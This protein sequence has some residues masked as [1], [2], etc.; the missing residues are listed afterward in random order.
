[1]YDS[2]IRPILLAPSYLK[3]ISGRSMQLVWHRAAEALL[4]AEQVE[5][6]GASLPSADS[7]VRA[8]LN[9]LRFRSDEGRVAL[10]V[11][12]PSRSDL[13]V[14]AAFMGSRAELVKAGIGER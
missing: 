10:R 3:Q 1:M 9:P 14:W 12:N 6:I 11:R 8:L 4:T 13:D 7:A 2:A 5:I